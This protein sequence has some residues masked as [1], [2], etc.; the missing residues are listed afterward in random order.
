MPLGLNVTN[1]G[2]VVERRPSF[3][4]R[5]SLIDR[6]VDRDPGSRWEAPPYRTLSRGEL[7][8]SV[9]RDLEWLLNTRTSLPGSLLDDKELTVIDYG[10]PDFGHY[11]PANPNHQ[12][13][14]AQ[15][16][17]RSISAF[18][19]RLQEVQVTVEPEMPDEKT[20]VIRIDAALIVEPFR[21][22]VSFQTVLQSQ[23]GRLEIHE[24]V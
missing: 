9:R 22:P 16:I 19:P 13:I 4:A 2:F 23:T 12:R 14:L 15:R 1:E 11:S 17:R 20:L 6:L 7:K 18:E 21:E 5:A 3:I 8:E 10:I 24:T